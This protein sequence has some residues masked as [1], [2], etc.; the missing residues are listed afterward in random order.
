MNISAYPTSVRTVLVMIWQNYASKS[1]DDQT[2][3]YYILLGL[4]LKFIAK[5]ASP[6]GFK[7]KPLALRPHLSILELSM[8][9]ISSRLQTSSSFK[10]TLH[11]AVQISS[12]C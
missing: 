3:T 1:S 4:V 9:K 8:I 7:C 2:N 6:D 11:Q 10:L 5:R 12:K